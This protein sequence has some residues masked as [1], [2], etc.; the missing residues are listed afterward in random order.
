MQFENRL[1]YHLRIDSISSR[2]TDQEKVFRQWLMNYTI[3]HGG[4]NNINDLPPV[5]I[6]SLEAH[7][8]VEQLVKK[9]AAVV[10]EQGNINFIYPVSALPTQHKVYLQD[11]REL[12]AM[13]AI[14]A[15]GVAFT[16]EQDTKIESKCCECGEDIF[17]Q[18]KEGK[19]VELFPE[20]THALHVDLEKFDDWAGNC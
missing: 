5:A 7:K 11:G 14:D 9:R 13:C 12:F 4:P 3:D 10:D 15:M 20:S 19:I 18:I 17:L 6:Q 8:L 1:K 16:F 2:L